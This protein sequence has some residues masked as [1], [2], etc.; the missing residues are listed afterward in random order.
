M[1]D[2]RTCNSDIT[3]KQYDR[4][5]GHAWPTDQPLCDACLDAGQR[6]IQAL[7]YDYL[8]LA[9]LHEASMSQAITEKTAG[10][11]EKQ[12][13]IVAHVEALQAEMVHVLTTWE[14]ELRV[15]ARLSDLEAPAVIPDWHTT[16]SNPPP[17]LKVRAGTA[18]QRAVGI[19]TPRVR[20]LSRLPATTVCATGVEDEHTEVTGWQAI[21]QLQALHQ[22]ARANLGRTRR[23]LSLHGTC[24]N[25][26]C[27][28]QALYRLEPGS[29]GEDP[30]VWCDTCKA[31]R[32]YSDYEHFMVHLEWPEQVQPAVAA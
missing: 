17:K 2:T 30:P 6:D 25:D 20:M 24:P 26:A 4:T 22:R 32:A 18:V 14:Y 29:F 15:A 7:V 23:I 13:L 5:A 8:D 9:Q 11:K 1:N 28:A 16:I 12:M 3:C 27:T 21:H 10:S 31:S 19:I